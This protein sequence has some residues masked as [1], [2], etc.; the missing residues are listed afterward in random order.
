MCPDTPGQDHPSP[1][2]PSDHHNVED[3]ADRPLVRSP[4]ATPGLQHCIDAVT[5]S[6]NRLQTPTLLLA[7]YEPRKA[8]RS[9]KS[10]P[11]ATSGIIDVA[12]G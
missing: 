1:D 9:Y 10:H 6:P 11:H 7:L 4:L 5:R 2:A 8:S 12:R 3:D